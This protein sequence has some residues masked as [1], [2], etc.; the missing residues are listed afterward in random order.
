MAGRLTVDDQP[1]MFRLEGGSYLRPRPR[2][3][4]GR[5]LGIETTDGS[6]SVPLLFPIATHPRDVVANFIVACVVAHAD[7]LP[8][9]TTIAGVPITT[10]EVAGVAIVIAGVDTVVVAVATAI[11]IATVI[12]TAAVVAT[13]G[14]PIIVSLV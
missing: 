14:L 5:Q 12:V 6:K 1:M 11:V 7:K 10:V 4:F 8:P 3:T 13:T 9:I 2:I